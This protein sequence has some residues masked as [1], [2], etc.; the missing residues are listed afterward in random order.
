MPSQWYIWDGRSG[1]FWVLPVTGSFGQFVTTIGLAA[2][3][4]GILQN[5]WW[6]NVVPA[7]MAFDYV[8]GLP[9]GWQNDPEWGDLRNAVEEYCA[10]RVLED[11]MEL[12]GAGLAGIS[13]SGQNAG[14]NWQFNRFRERLEKLKANYESFKQTLVEQETSSP[15]MVM[16]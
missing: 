6:A 11:L 4:V 15:M 5:G 13:A 16:I 7:V 1:R 12:P 14:Q 8:C 10:M 2:A 3:T 9:P